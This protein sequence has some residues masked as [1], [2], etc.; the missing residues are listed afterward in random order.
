[1]AEPFYN[2]GGLTSSV[3][4]QGTA[5]DPTPYDSGILTSSQTVVIPVSGFYFIEAVGGGGKGQ[6]VDASLV[7]AGMFSGMGGRNGTFNSAI[8]FLNRDDTVSVAIGAGGT[9]AS[10]QAGSTSVQT[11]AYTLQAPG[12]SNQAVF[13]VTTAWS[14]RNLA[15]NYQNESDAQADPRTAGT[16]G[17]MYTDVRA[18]GLEV[19]YVRAGS[20]MPDVRFSGNAGGS[21]RSASAID[22]STSTGYRNG[23][24]GY[25]GY[26]G[27]GGQGGSAKNGNSS[28][29]GNG[30]DGAARIVRI[31]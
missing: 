8:V 22:D 20:G 14:G 1:M 13:T 29:G 17:K 11:Q 10:G 25:A 12:G 16:I 9:V 19:T 6:G 5:Y 15:Y 3:D 7:S 26:Y 21:I 18:D 24:T 31:G 27:T 2:Y 30:L 4:G 23:S 28:V